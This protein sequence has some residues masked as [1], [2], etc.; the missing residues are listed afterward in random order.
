MTGK[1]STPVPLVPHSEVDAVL[2]ALKHQQQLTYL[3]DG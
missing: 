2:L 1:K 3:T